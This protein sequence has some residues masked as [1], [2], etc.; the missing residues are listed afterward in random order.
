MDSHFAMCNEHTPLEALYGQRITMWL[1]GT[2][3]Y[4]NATEDTYCESMLLC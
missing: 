2:W 1:G 4:G 3:Q